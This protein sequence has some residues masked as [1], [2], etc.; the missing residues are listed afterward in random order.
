VPP[1]LAGPAYLGAMRSAQPKK[2]GAVRTAIKCPNMSVGRG[3]EEGID[4][5]C[6]ELAHSYRVHIDRYASQLCFGE[7]VSYVHNFFLF[8]NRYAV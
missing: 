4:G 1:V 6:R 8:D 5:V 3:G 2:A 7:V